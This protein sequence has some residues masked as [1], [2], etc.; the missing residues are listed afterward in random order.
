MNPFL[1]GDPTDE[2]HQRDIF[3]FLFVEVTLL[4]EKFRVFMVA[5]GLCF[6][7]TCSFVLPDSVGERKRMG[8]LPENSSY[9]RLS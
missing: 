5:W 8:V 1:P 3:P 6:E 9:V 4:E 7:D 2:G